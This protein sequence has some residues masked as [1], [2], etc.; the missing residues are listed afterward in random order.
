MNFVY[1]VCIMP[2]ILVF[3]LQNDSLLPGISWS[4]DNFPIQKSSTPLNN[5]SSLRNLNSLNEE[6]N[7]DILFVIRNNF[8]L[9]ILNYHIT[10]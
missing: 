8:L 7:N 9:L 3:Q 2:F 5:L 10:Y 4:T 6:V 1:Y